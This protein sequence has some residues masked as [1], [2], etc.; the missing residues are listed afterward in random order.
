MSNF[1]YE[2]LRLVEPYRVASEEARSAVHAEPLLLAAKE[3]ASVGDAVADCHVVC[4]TTA[5][6]S[7]EVTLPLH[8]L[9][10]AAERLRSAAGRRAI[11]FGS[12]KF[13]LSNEDMS[14]C[15]SLV[16]IPTLPAHRSMNLGQAVAVTLYEMSREPGTAVD[17]PLEAADAGAN[18]RI[19]QLL[20][21]ALGESGYLKPPADES[22]TLKTRRLV[23]RMELSDN[24][25]VVVQGMLRQILW[26]LRKM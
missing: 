3:Y 15:H 17:R 11:L 20:L 6:G 5:V 22:Q 18:E 4:G 13:G 9:T 2:E 26:K 1:G 16:R 7:R 25:A 14:H 21:E 8:D 10:V 23:G 19:V 12:E 24:D